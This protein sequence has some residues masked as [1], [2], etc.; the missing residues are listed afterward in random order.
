MVDS[1]QLVT[2]SHIKPN[3]K[4]FNEGINSEIGTRSNEPSPIRVNRSNLPPTKVS[5]ANHVLDG[6]HSWPP[7]KNIPAIQPVRSSGNATRVQHVPSGW[8]SFKRLPAATINCTTQEAPLGINH[9]G[10]LSY[11]KNSALVAVPPTHMVKRVPAHIKVPAKP[12][13]LSACESPNSTHSLPHPSSY[14]EQSIEAH[15][16][17]NVSKLKTIEQTGPN[18]NLEDNVGHHGQ[19][20]DRMLDPMD[21]LDEMVGLNSKRPRVAPI[22]MADYVSK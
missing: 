22:W 20:I 10:N 12:F 15:P 9:V 2:G 19:R 17:T 4:F 1:S 14:L 13:S 11:N 5:R 16:I 8:T 3:S 18:I 7:L 21:N 6:S